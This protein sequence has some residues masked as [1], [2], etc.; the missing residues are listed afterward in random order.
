ML[1]M[2]AESDVLGKVTLGC[3]VNSDVLNP[4]VSR[5]EMEKVFL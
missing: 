4:G 2:H 5:E 3:G 1:V